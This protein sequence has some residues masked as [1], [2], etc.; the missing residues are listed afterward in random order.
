VRTNAP[1]DRWPEIVQIAE[2]SRDADTRHLV[3]SP[4]RYAGH[5]IGD[6]GPTSMTQLDMD[7]VAELSIELFGSD[8]R[9]A[10]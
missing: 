5:V 2:R 10:P 1:L 6:F 3:L 8:S 4:P 7:A 9:Y